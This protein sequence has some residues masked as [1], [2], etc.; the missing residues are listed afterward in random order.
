MATVPVS[1]H[2]DEPILIGT[3]IHNALSKNSS[4]LVEITYQIQAVHKSDDS[5][6]FKVL[7]DL[8]YFMN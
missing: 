1:I 3:E 8:H 7:E 5:F 2:T 6:L 4:V